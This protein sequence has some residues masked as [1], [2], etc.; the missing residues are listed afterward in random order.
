ME[1]P[2]TPNEV[3][4]MVR[5]SCKTVMRAIQAGEL[6]ASQLARKRGGW[7]VMPAAVEE[8][9]QARSSRRRPPRALPDVSRVEPPVLRR[10]GRSP[11]SNGSGRLAA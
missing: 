4:E 10:G 6:E 9:V 2:M 5:V 1:R 8:W 11:E 3:A 7:R